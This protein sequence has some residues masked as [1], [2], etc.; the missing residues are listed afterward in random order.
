[1]NLFESIQNNLK[2]AANEVIANIKF[3]K[4]LLG[5]GL[6]EENYSEMDETQLYS[7]LKKYEEEY[8]NSGIVNYIAYILYYNQENNAGN[9]GYLSANGVSRK[10]YNINVYPN[11]EEANKALEE[12][13]ST[14]N[15]NIE[16]SRV[17]VLKF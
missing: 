12:Y 17:E 2:E 4:G 14:N 1:M 13:A 5:K 6:N 11:E 10:K 16:E 7:I 8:N 3:V 9:A 15:L